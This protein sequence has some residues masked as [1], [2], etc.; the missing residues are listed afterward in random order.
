MEPLTC[1]DSEEEMVDEEEDKK[2]FVKTEN[3]LFLSFEADHELEANRC[4][5]LNEVA[6]A[7]VNTLDEEHNNDNQLLSGRRIVDTHFSKK[8]WNMENYDQKCVEERR[9]YHIVSSHITRQISSKCLKEFTLIVDCCLRNSQ[10]ERPTMA[11]VVVALQFS[12][13]LQE[14]FERRSKEGDYFCLQA[15][16]WSSYYG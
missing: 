16:L 5:K 8:D 12:I 7:I 10:K 3:L 2:E 4:W 1:S 15:A 13:A 6:K 11:T 9:L 14:Q